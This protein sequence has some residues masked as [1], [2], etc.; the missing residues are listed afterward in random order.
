VPAKTMTTHQNEPFSDL[1]PRLT[2]PEVAH[3]SR[4]QAKTIRNLV[5]LGKLSASRCGGRL[6][7]DRDEIIAWIEG[8]A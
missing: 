3:L 5:Y 4:K 8:R 6:L 7:F 2:T 1:P